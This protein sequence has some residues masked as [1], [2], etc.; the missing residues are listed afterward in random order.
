MP[1]GDSCK[2]T[3]KSRI[4]VRFRHTAVISKS[5]NQ[6]P[7]AQCG[8]LQS[9]VDDAEEDGNEEPSSH[10]SDKELHLIEKAKQIYLKGVSAERSGRMHDDEESNGSETDCEDNDSSCGNDNTASLHQRIKM[11]TPPANICSVALEQKA[12]HISDLPREVFMFILRWVVSSDLDILSL[13]AVSKVCRGFYLCARDPELWHTACVRTWGEDCGQLNQYDSWREMYI[14]RPRIC[15]NGVYINRTT[16][17][18]HG[19][20]SFQDSS[21]RPCFLVE[22]FRY[23][24]FFPDGV[25]LMLTTPDNP[26][27]SLGKLRSRRPAYTSVLRGSF[28]LEG[29]RVKAVLKKPAMKTPRNTGYWR[30]VRHSMEP[31][32]DQVFHLEL[33]LRSVRGR[34]NA[35]LVWKSYAI[36]SYWLG[37]ESVATFDLTT[38]AFPPLWFSRVKSFTNVAESPL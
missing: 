17:V 14:C 33:E 36:H 29:T 8:S 31:Q 15:Y 7:P 13:E 28:W 26:Y 38:N 1:A 23:L 32:P 3:H 10:A 9:G 2:A 22:Y 34:A 4:R 19:E 12:T 25:V 37:Q 35:Q 30:G 24:R 6:Q 18:R 11:K 20:S 21:Y 27:V 16:Y 5:D